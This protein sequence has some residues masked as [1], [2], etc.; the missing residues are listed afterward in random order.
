MDFDG[1][2]FLEGAIISFNGGLLCEIERSCFSFTIDYLDWHLMNSIQADEQ[3]P[4][5]IS[6]TVGELTK[7]DRLQGTPSETFR[8]YIDLVAASADNH[9][10]ALSHQGVPQ[11]KVALAE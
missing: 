10:S 7:S 6:A 5:V 9:V 4:L 8:E 2:N 3:A 11:P 1:G